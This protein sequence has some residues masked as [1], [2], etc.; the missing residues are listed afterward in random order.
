MGSNFYSGTDAELA[1]GAANV[2]A[3]VTPSPS[4]YGLAAPIVA[5][6]TALSDSFSAKLALATA[7]ATRT[8]VIVGEKNVLKQ[9]LKRA[10]VNLA[11]VMTATDTVTNAMLLSLR[12]NER[13][14][15]RRRRPVPANAPTV[16]VVSVVN[17]LVKVHVHDAASASR[18]LPF[19][20]IS[21]NL[22]SFVGPSAPTDPREFHFEGATTRARTQ[23]LFPDGIASGATVWLS[24]C[25]VSARG[26][27]SA[28]STPISFTLQ[29]GAPPA[30]SRAA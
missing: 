27:R 30:V 11:R 6:Y 24:A 21:A 2:V 17:R 22:Y 3:V 15:K 1:S 7:P 29:G 13:V 20:A 16:D 4:T 14:I 18:G 10:S 5:S 26:Q 25:W 23:I 19:G 9:A 28:G 8:S 12:M